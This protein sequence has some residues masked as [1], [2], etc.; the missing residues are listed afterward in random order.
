MI[1]KLVRFKDYLIVWIQTQVWRRW[2][3]RWKKSNIMNKNRSDLKN[4]NPGLKK[5]ENQMN[6]LRSVP[7]LSSLHPTIIAKLADVLEPVIFVI[8]IFTLYTITI[9]TITI[10]TT[11]SITTVTIAIKIIPAPDHHRQ[12]GW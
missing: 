7:L 3:T 8:K 4:K 10:I 5:M 6:F 2:K 1:I 11:T 12:A 9:T